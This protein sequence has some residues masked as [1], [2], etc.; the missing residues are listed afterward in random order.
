MNA[1]MGV[2]IALLMKNEDKFG[3]EVNYEGSLV[4]FDANRIKDWQERENI[5]GLWIGNCDNEPED[6]LVA[7]SNYDFKIL[8]ETLKP[9]NCIYYNGSDSPLAILKKADFLAM[10]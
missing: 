9:Y 3:I 6:F 10:S 2:V 5:Y 4:Y 1:D 8:P 7:I